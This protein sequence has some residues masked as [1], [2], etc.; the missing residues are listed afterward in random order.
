MGDKLVVQLAL[1][2]GSTLRPYQ[3]EGIHQAHQ[4]P[5]DERGEQRVYERFGEE[6]EIDGLFGQRYEVNYAMVRPITTDRQGG[7]GDSAEHDAK[8]ALAALLGTGVDGA[9][10][11]TR[12]TL[13]DEAGQDGSR[14]RQGIP[15]P[16]CAHN[17]SVKSSNP[18]EFSPLQEK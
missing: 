11:G 4:R 13:Q 1:G 16:L 9:E 3:H 8:D 15:T 10:D 12:H 2:G 14:A 18:C 5:D 17:Y 7:A 6:G